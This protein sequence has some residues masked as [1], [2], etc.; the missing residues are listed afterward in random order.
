MV[1]ARC[2]ARGESCRERLASPHTLP[3]PKYTATSHHP[4][5]HPPTSP[6]VGGDVAHEVTPVEAHAHHAA[7][8]LQRETRGGGPRRQQQQERQRGAGEGTEVGRD[9]LLPAQSCGRGPRIPAMASPL[10]HTRPRTAHL[11]R[12]AVA[13]AGTIDNADVGGCSRGRAGRQAVGRGSGTAE[14]YVQ[15]DG[16]AARTV[17]RHTYVGPLQHTHTPPS[18][19]LPTAPHPPTHPPLNPALAW[20]RK[21]GLGAPFM[22]TMH[23]LPKPLHCSI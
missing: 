12:G 23:L 10:T 14:R 16:I 5:T 9:G 15:W 2:A 3:R 11:H 4:P 17:C 19:A 20:M 18:P 6:S 13:H 8:D 22:S 7:A 1:G 21:S